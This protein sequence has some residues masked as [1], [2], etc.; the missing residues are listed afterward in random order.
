MI[1]VNYK[2][3]TPQPINPKDK[4]AA[5]TQKEPTA[6]EKQA[7]LD[8][9][10]KIKARLDKG[11][12]FAKVAGETSDDLITKKKGGDAGQ[13]SKDDKRFERLGL[14]NLVAQAFQ[15]KKDQVSNPIEGKTAYYLVK[16]TSDPIVV[17]YEEAERML[18]F[19]LQGNVKQKIVDQLRTSAKVEFAVSNDGNVNQKGSG[20]TTVP[21]EQT[22]PEDT[23]S[24][25]TKQNWYET[26]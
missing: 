1:A 26:K 14:S 7:A 3:T 13:I 20:Q 4:N 25:T 21:V 19:E 11:D 5:S 6:Q 8:K 16:V 24:D 22:T 12:D 23:Q 15:L 10:K 9:V 18:R 2:P 17:P